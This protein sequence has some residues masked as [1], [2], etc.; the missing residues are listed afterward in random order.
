MSWVRV[1]FNYKRVLEDIASHP[2]PPPPLV[3][4]N[5]LSC[6][7]CGASDQLTVKEN[8]NVTH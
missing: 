7:G 4:E 5:V 8:L 3:D 6:P 2:P 1:V